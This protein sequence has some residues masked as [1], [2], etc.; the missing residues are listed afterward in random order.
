MRMS[1][2]NPGAVYY[3]CDTVRGIV[4]AVIDTIEVHGQYPV[5]VVVR[6]EDLKDGVWC[7]GGVGLCCD[8]DNGADIMEDRLVDHLQRVDGESWEQAIQREVN[9]GLADSDDDDAD[10]YRYELGAEAFARGGMTGYNEAMGYGTVDDPDEYWDD[11]YWDDE[12]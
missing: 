5:F 3:S 11:E 1:D 7:A 2:L 10:D 8:D 12:Y 9:E 4:V 6:D